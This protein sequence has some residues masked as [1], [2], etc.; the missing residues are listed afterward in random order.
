MTRGKRIRMITCRRESGESPLCSSP[1]HFFFFFAL[2]AS[3]GRKGIG[4]CVGVLLQHTRECED[5]MGYQ[6]NLSKAAGWSKKQEGKG[7]ACVLI[8][9]I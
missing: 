5:A 3:V 4:L 2:L 7:G 8:F 1:R 6:T 9:S